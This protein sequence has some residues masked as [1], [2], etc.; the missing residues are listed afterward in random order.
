MIKYAKNKNINVVLHTNATLINSVNSK[1]IINSGLD[2]IS[3]SLDVFNKETYEE[4]RVNA[5]FEETL[6]NIN[7]FLKI[8]N[9]R[10]AKKPYTIIQFFKN[11]Q[12]NKFKKTSEIF[13]EKNKSFSPDEFRLITPH[14]WAGVITPIKKR[15]ENQ[16]YKPCRF[17]WFGMAIAWDG[18]V[19]T[20]CDD[21][22]QRNR[23]GNIKNENLINLWNNEKIF[24]I[25]RAIAEGRYQ[26]VNICSNCDNLWIEKFN[27][28]LYFPYGDIASRIIFGHRLVGNLKR[29]LTDEK[30]IFSG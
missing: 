13:F 5:H 19:V 23:I 21:I 4:L 18:T 7:T 25:R 9:E 11:I 17:L 20:C 24:S 28:Q 29:L 22:L 3:F 16:I 27:P 26:D 8:K 30:P 15:P 14:N 10:F 1:K 12:L 6:N 2:L